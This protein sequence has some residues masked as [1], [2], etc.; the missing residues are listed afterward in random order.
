MQ[1]KLIILDRD[2]I[3]NKLLFIDNKYESP[4]SIEQI[5][6]FYWVP[7]ELKKICDLNYKLSIATNQPSFAKGKNS[8]ENLLD[9]NN[10]II[11]ICES[12]GAKISSYH[13]CFHRSEDQCDCRKPNIRLLEDAIIYNNIINKDNCWMVGDRTTDIIAGYNFGINTALVN[14]IIQDDILSL[15]EKNITPSFIG[16]DLRDLVKVLK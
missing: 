9:I 2:G 3:L 12:K 1:D 10:F 6:V 14:C 8:K 5:D 4:M 13:I 7:E 11:K 16:N 15:K